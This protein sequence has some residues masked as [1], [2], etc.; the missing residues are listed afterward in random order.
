MSPCLF[1]QIATLPPVVELLQEWSVEQTETLLEKIEVDKE[2]RIEE[3][4]QRRRAESN[5]YATCLEYSYATCLEYLTSILQFDTD[6]SANMA[7]R[8][9]FTT[10][11]NY[12]T[13]DPALIAGN[14]NICSLVLLLL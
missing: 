4:L 3:E 2:Q 1:Y 9:H 12:I 6:R 14:Y 11:I 7:W 13:Y 8:K 10:L 5:K